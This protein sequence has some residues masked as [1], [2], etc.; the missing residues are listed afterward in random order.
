M[1]QQT[2]LGSRD[3]KTDLITAQLYRQP[4]SHCASFPIVT[5]ST[6]MRGVS[7]TNRTL[8]K[9]VPGKGGMA[10]SSCLSDAS[11]DFSLFKPLSS[12]VSCTPVVLHLDTKSGALLAH[13]LTTVL[14]DLFV[15]T[16][17]RGRSPRGL[18]REPCLEMIGSG[19]I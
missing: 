13:F 7:I 16:R 4:V 11:W 1:F 6:Q 14:N 12:G 5:Q 10:A 8:Q 3:C 17:S 15:S 19:T 9:R 2:V 18:H